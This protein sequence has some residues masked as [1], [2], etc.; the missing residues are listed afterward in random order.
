MDAEPAEEEPDLRSAIEVIKAL[1]QEHGQVPSKTMAAMERMLAEAGPHLR[2]VGRARKVSVSMPEDLTIAVQE[3]V[4]RGEFS[5]YVT[6]AVA[7][8]LE[9]DLLGDLSALLH[10]KHGPVPEELLAEARLAWPDAR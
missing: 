10:A 5:H 6:G 2:L 9:V 3:R 8:Q 1:Q 4:G 7:R